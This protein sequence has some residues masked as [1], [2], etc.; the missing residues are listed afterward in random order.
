MASPQKENGF[1]PIANEI[2]EHLSE[3]GI[4]GS[5]FRI[6]LF[7]IRKTY[8][9]QK[10]KDRISISQFKKATK[11]KQGQAVKT[12][13]TLVGKRVLLKEGNSYIFNKNWEEWVVGKRLPS[14][15]KPTGG[16]RQKGTESS[17]Q[18]PTHK[19]KKEIETKEMLSN[20]SGILIPE[21]IKLFE[22]INPACKRYYGN[23][24]QR[25][26]CQDLLDTYGFEELTKV[27]AF[28]P[29]N[30]SSPFKPK[31][32]TPLQLWEKF[33]SIKDSWLQEKNKQFSKFK[34]I[35]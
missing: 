8:G 14:T 7:V 24:T 25:K 30:N 5:E 34:G 4:N 3:P 26:A 16:S 35:A 1:T 19:R 32:N 27:I 23:L 11:M 29:K 12:I 15:Q 22:G 20:E 33:Q 21:V 28:L 13:K 9:F 10:R 18:K 17:R 2:L 6:L 31:A